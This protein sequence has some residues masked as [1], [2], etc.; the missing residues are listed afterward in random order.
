MKWHET[1]KTKGIVRG[2]DK[3]TNFNMAAMGNIGNM[4]DAELKASVRT[5]YKGLLRLTENRIILVW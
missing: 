5:Y 2:D 3:H 4:G 1:A